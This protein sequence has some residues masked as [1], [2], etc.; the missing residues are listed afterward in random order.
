MCHLQPGAEY[1]SALLAMA[2]PQCPGFCH[3]ETC[4]KGW[5][6]TIWTR[7]KSL[8][9]MLRKWDFRMFI[10][11]TCWSDLMQFTPLGPRKFKNYNFPRTCSGF[12]EQQRRRVAVAMMDGP[13][14]WAATYVLGAWATS[15]VL[16]KAVAFQAVSAH[17]WLYTAFCPVVCS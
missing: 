2:L 7:D 6:E 9:W 12:I 4:D 17:C 14:Q 10:L 3:R 16:Q 5:K 13:A 1:G 11:Y 8:T 15:T